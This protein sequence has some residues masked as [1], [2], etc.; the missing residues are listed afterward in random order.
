MIKNIVKDVAV[1]TTFQRVLRISE[2]TAGISF[3]FLKSKSS[4]SE[5]VRDFI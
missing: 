2:S 5:I 3:V 4:P 1:V